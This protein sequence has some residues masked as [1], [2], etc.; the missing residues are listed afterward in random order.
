MK[1]GETK[2]EKVVMPK[3]IERR[4]MLRL[5]LPSVLTVVLFMIAMFVV[6]IP[7]LEN[8][9]MERK[10]ETIRELSQVAWD[11]LAFYHQEELNGRF[12]RAEA[13]RRAVAQLR[14]MRYGGE[15]KDYFWINNLE[16]RIIMHPYR[17]DLEGQLVSDFTD[18]KGKHLFVEVVE[19]VKRS[20]H[21]YVDYMWQWKDDPGRIVP[22]VSF[23]REFQPWAWVV[24]TGIYLD[25]VAREIASITNRLS[26]VS[27]GI[28][29]VVA[30]LGFYMVQQ[31]LASERQRW[32]AQQDLESSRWMLRLVMDNIPQLIF[33]KDTEG[34]Y[35]GG[36]QAVAA[37][38]GI[39]DPEQIEGLNDSQFTM[40]QGEMDRLRRI[41][42]EV[43][44][45]G[46]PQLHVVEPHRRPDGDE[47]WMDTNRI[48]L[49]DAEGEVVGILCT[50]D[51]ITHRREMNRA[52]Q[53]SERRFRT[54]VEN[55]QVGISIVH[56]GSI[57]YTNPEQERIMGPLRLPFP[58][59][60]LEGSNS[61]EMAKLLDLAREPQGDEGQ[62]L[63]LDLGFLRR[64]QEDPGR[65]SARWVHCRTKRIMYQGDEALLV[66]M[67]DITKAKELEHLVRVQDKMAS[68]GRVAAG[69]AHEIRNPLSGINM[70][71]TA[72]RTKAATGQ[73][74]EIDELLTKVQSASAKI[75]G[76]IRRVLDFAKPSTPKLTWVNPNQVVINILEL[77][78]VTARKGG[79]MIQTV[80]ADDLPLVHADAQLLEQVMLNLVTNAVQALG[81]VPGEKKIL[82][83]TAMERERIIMQV[84]DNG[85]GVP[86]EMRDRIF[87]PFFTNK[88]D[89]SGI[90]LSLC[91]RIISD[92]GGR[93]M[94]AAST[95]GGALFTIELPAAVY[96]G[97][98]SHG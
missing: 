22:K 70:Y 63:E 53:E 37:H 98:D 67:L 94:V 72:L 11:I 21:G 50:Y 46:E 82:L 61:P 74:P 24:G 1:P 20:E 93:L 65:R 4:P 83:T 28:L 49:K 80:L 48:P 32:K 39:G 73:G 51:D 42:R 86:P 78:A 30:L 87:D 14:Q 75:E 57:I 55:A 60:A 68:L 77:S 13:Q 23:V 18:P 12:S 91:H 29:L 26:M 5:V 59:S 41:E 81:E 45:S 6:I 97:Y 92:H 36:N 43:M 19:V 17:T 85:P 38:V 89:G 15:N 96:W 33:W 95:M 27:I 52:L 88:K 84:A 7:A 3:R 71:L 64:G 90:G 2:H 47:V 62:I 44:S 35:L 31:S 40:D 9:L 56:Q 34:V 79:I 66:I 8:N 25:D 16:P 58:L 10:R 69:I 76:V 54:L